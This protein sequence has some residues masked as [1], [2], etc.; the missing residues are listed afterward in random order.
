MMREWRGRTEG[1]GPLA[2][3]RSI[4]LDRS[5][6]FVFSIPSDVPSNVPRG[7]ARRAQMEEVCMQ[8]MGGGVASG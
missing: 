1:G 5:D 2:W 4:S 7:N 3:I 8:G 6:S